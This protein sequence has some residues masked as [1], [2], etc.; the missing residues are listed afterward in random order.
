VLREGLLNQLFVL[1]TSPGFSGAQSCRRS[2]EVQPVLPNWKNHLSPII[3]AWR[4]AISL[5]VRVKGKMNL[6]QLIQIHEC[7][8][9]GIS[10]FIA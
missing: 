3:L 4:R 1:Y 8:S 10:K 7:L 9:I 2:S 5:I 6:I